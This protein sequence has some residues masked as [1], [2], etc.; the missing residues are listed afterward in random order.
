MLGMPL[1]FIW[2]IPRMSD[3]DMLAVFWTAPVL[4][5]A[6]AVVTRGQSG[7]VLTLAAAVIGFV[8]I[9][10]ICKPDAGVFRPSALLA[11]G[12]ALCLALYLVMSRAMRHEAELTKLV[13]TALWVFVPLT[14]VL[15]LFWQ[16]PTLQGLA[17]MS[18]IGV[19]SCGMLFALD[20]A[21]ERVPPAF[22]APVLYTQFA[23]DM[24]LRWSLHAATPD[25]R[26]LT[27]TLLVFAAAGAAVLW[28]AHQ[29]PPSPPLL[30][31][32]QT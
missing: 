25:A 28:S 15:P 5:I 32:I 11:L 20:R 3:Q 16:M 6:I 18:A 14:F 22:L 21:V 12:M 4:V 23:W 13:H 9:V 1:C 10:L 7:G 8:G 31:S 26:T 2:A 17:A 19:M 30:S 24:L 27:G 29:A